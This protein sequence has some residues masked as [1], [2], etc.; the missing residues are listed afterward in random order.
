[1]HTTFLKL[2]CLLIVGGL[3]VSA[4]NMPENDV[5][6]EVTSTQTEEPSTPTQT[7][8]V[9]PTNTET[10][11]ATETLVPE[12]S[13]TATPEAVK[14]DVV[15]ETNC[16]TG[17][18]GNYDLIARYQVGQLLEV[19]AKDLGNGYFFVKN[20]EKAEEQCYLLA[21]NIKVTGDT[22]ALPKLTP[23]PSPTAAPYFNVTF[24]KFDIC[25]GTNFALFTVENTGSAPFRS[26]YIKVTEQKGKSVEQ[27]LNAFDL[28]SRCVLAKNIAPLDPGGIGYVHTPPFKWSGHG[29]KLRAVIMLCTEK[30]LKGTCVTQTVDIKD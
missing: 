8:K 23:L 1:M 27:A 20:P 21:Q 15:R 29:S 13:E 5:A 19:V 18:A 12:P 2:A 3:I 24:K 14:A 6:I 26:A 10:V 11:T 30:S 16:R 28:F 22:D 4:C 17:P 7:A 25:E 9:L